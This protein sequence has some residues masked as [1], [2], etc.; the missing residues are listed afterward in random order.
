MNYSENFSTTTYKDNAN[1]NAGWS[2]GQLI[3]TGGAQSSQ[4]YSGNS[5]QFDSGG[6]TPWTNPQNARVLDGNYASISLSNKLSNYTSQ[7]LVQTQFG[8]SIPA[9]AQINGVLV[10]IYT[11]Y[12][13]ADYWA[14]V[15]LV[16]AGSIEA[17]TGHYGNGGVNEPAL[18][19]HWEP[20][21]GSSDLW[22]GALSASDVNASNFGCAYRQSENSSTAYY[23]YADDCRMTVYYLYYNYTTNYVGQSLNINSTANNVLSATLSKTDNVPGGTSITYQLSND[24]GVT[25]N[26]V[27]PGTPYTFGTSGNDLRWRVL[28]NGT[29]T[30]TPSVSALSINYSLK[31]ASTLSDNLTTSD[32]YSRIGN[33][34]RTLSDTIS[35]SDSIITLRVLYQIF[36]EA[37][38]TSDNLLKSLSKILS[39]AISSSE[40]IGKTILKS[41]LDSISSIELFVLK[42]A[43]RNKNIVAN[44]SQERI[45]ADTKN[46]IIRADIDNN[47]KIGG[48]NG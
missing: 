15:R 40:I 23:T 28:L 8:F 17:S 42:Y 18:T 41:L 43:F 11:Y 16:R 31:Y 36:L 29:A 45:V 26:T 6:Y 7:F 4:K 5:A 22:A 20:S 1:N 27:T 25:W 33:F 44:I 34:F 30:S 24:G 21:G 35:T 12:Q 46:G 32:V 39:D 10:E 9:G 3:I 19:W 2:S 14:G 13:Q 37:I 38:N 47:K 48:I